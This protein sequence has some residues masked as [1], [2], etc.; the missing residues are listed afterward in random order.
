MASVQQGDL[1]PAAVDAL[2]NAL[3]GR[4]RAELLTNVEGIAAAAATR[5]LEAFTRPAAQQATQLGSVEA[6]TVVSVEWTFANSSPVPWPSGARLVFKEGDLQPPQG[7]IPWQ[8]SQATP[9]GMSVTASARML[10]PNRSGPCE[11]RWRL[12]ASDGAP[13]SEQ[14]SVKAAVVSGPSGSVSN[15]NKNSAPYA[16]SGQASPNMTLQHG[17]DSASQR[18]PAAK[19]GQP[20]SIHGTP[21]QAAP[22]KS[23]DSSV[24]GNFKQVNQAPSLHAPPPAMMTLQADP[25]ST[26]GYTNTVP[27]ERHPAQGGGSTPVYQVPRAANL[28]SDPW[29]KYFES[30]IGQDLVRLL[31]ETDNDEKVVQRVI[32]K[33]FEH[34]KAKSIFRADVCDL[35][36]ELMQ[37]F[38]P[39]NAGK[40]MKQRDF[41]PHVRQLVYIYHQRC[42]Q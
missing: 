15:S 34:A 42:R 21:V 30:F 26:L 35:D 14:L 5:A 29:L 11:G 22:A 8:A 28:S 16:V 24:V 36:A 17:V 39:L 20:V 23:V 6:G 41:L 33:V 40:E 10:V 3:L 31:K 7:C 38:S 32:N 1:S 13:L 27:S 37:L 25:N 9:P 2:C 19:M 4:L 12:E 18:S